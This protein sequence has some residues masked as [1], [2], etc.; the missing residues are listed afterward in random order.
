MKNSLFVALRSDRLSCACTVQCSH[1]LTPTEW[2]TRAANT[3][4]RGGN[5]GFTLWMERNWSPLPWHGNVTKDIPW[6]CTKFQFYTLNFFRDFIHFLWFYI[7]LWQSCDVTSQ[8]ICI[9]QILN[10]SATNNS[11]KVEQMH[12]FIILKALPNELIK[13]FLSYTA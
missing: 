1:S 5:S 3:S 11:I 8:L 13:D 12:L 9:N 4:R 7:I 10:N 2:K 6:N